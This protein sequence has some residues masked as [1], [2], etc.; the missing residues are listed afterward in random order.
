MKNKRFT[1]WDAW[2]APNKG[3]DAIIYSIIEIGTT[4]YLMEVNLNKG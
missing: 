4:L 3:H 1:I 2:E